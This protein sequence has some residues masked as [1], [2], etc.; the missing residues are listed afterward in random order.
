MDDA[1]QQCSIEHSTLTEINV[2]RVELIKA[3][4]GPEHL[5]NGLVST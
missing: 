3:L 1:L 4:I 2:G 5:K